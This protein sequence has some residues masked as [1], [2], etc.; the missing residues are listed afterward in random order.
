MRTFNHR[1][2]RQIKPS[3]VLKSLRM[4]LGSL[5]KV[6][7]WLNCEKFLKG[8]LPTSII[9]M[10][11]VGNANWWLTAPSTSQRHYA[12][13]SFSDWKHRYQLSAHHQQ[14]KLRDWWRKKGIFRIFDFWVFYDVLVKSDQD[15]FTKTNHIWGFLLKV[16]FDA[17][18]TRRTKTLRICVPGRYMVCEN[19]WQEVTNLLRTMVR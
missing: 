10:V 3:F 15:S 16:E 5:W 4:D 13:R 14:L 1:V 12:K 6:R 2:I 11:V 9:F 8:P 17:N 18:P 7:C 19:Q